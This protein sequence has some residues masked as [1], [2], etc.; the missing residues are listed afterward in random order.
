[1]LFLLHA[2][3]HFARLLA[4]PI[5]ALLMDTHLWIPFSVALSMMALRFVLIWLLPETMPCAMTT[6]ERPDACIQKAIGPQSSGPVQAPRSAVS[7]L[8][9]ITWMVSHTGLIIT[10]AS[11]IVKRIAF[12]SESL[13][14]QYASEKMHKKLSETVWL[15]VSNT[16][17][18]TFAL[19]TVL[20]IISRFGPW[21]S[22]RKDLWA[23]RGSLTGAALGSFVL[24]GGNN[25]TALC[26]GMVICGLAEGLEPSLQALGSF[27]VGP[28]LNANF[29]SFVSMLDR[30][31]ELLGGIT[32]AA[33]YS[34][35]NL[36]GQPAGYNFLLSMLLFS[37]LWLASWAMT[38]KRLHV[39]R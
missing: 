38:T 1:M 26:I 9:T 25:F 24:F 10:F 11:F 14:F 35:R 5:G 3:S 19:G 22:P 2:V 8:S 39:E 32:M 15:R 13:A 17:G 23:M 12:S 37:L 33:A 4:P 30:I 20:P 6:S 16:A 7:S 21:T 34:I 29:F 18:A 28:S 36:D 31:A 27:I